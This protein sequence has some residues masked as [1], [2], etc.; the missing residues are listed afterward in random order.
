MGGAEVATGSVGQLILD[1]I[2]TSKGKAQKSAESACRNLNLVVANLVKS[3]EQ[4]VLTGWQ[5]SN[6][7]ELPTDS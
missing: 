1:S 7:V 5:M 2:L 3:I 6:A 4:G